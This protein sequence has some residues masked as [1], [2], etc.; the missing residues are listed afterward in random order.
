MDYA[1]L[2]LAPAL[3]A[4]AGGLAFFLHGMTMMSNALRAMAVSR[5]KA[6]LA[7]LAQNR[8]SPLLSGA[9]VT[10]SDTPP[11]QLPTALERALTESLRRGYSLTRRVVRVG[12]GLD[13][14]TAQDA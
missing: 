3:I 12:A 11:R 1:S 6:L 13:D 7:R 14:M 10:A 2:S 8:V 5:L 9:T 4:L